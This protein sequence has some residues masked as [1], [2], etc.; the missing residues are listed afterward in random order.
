M[1]YDEILDYPH[2]FRDTEA[3]NIR[4]YLFRLLEALWLEGEGFSGKRPFGN[5]GWDYDIYLPLV[6]MGAVKGVIEVEDEYEYLDT[7]DRK[8]A[9][10]LVYD[11]I[12]Y[13]FNFE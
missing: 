3:K 7:F 5:S 11:L 13:V 8:D 4:H 12:A 6:K 9:D 10:K 2:E 1:T